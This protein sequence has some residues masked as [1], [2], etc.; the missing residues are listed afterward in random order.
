MSFFDFVTSQFADNILTLSGEIIITPKTTSD[1]DEIAEFDV[2][3]LNRKLDELRHKFGFLRINVI[4]GLLEINVKF[5]CSNARINQE[6]FL[7]EYNECLKNVVMDILQNNKLFVRVNVF[8][9][10][11]TIKKIS[12]YRY[13]NKGK[14]VRFA[15]TDEIYKGSSAKFMRPISYFIVLL[16]AACSYFGYQGYQ[17]FF[18]DKNK[19]KVEQNDANVEKKKENEPELNEKDKKVKEKDK[20]IMEKEIP[21]ANKM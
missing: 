4:H 7:E 21:P 13:L 12:E 17:Y 11:E 5:F 9:K 10:F 2:T 1:K 6:N 16:I 18:A 8:G 15:I 3:A 20:E 14:E 19:A